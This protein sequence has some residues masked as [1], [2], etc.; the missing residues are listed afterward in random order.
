MSKIKNGGLHRYG[1]GPFEQ[2]QLGTAGVEGVNTYNNNTVGAHVYSHLLSLD[3]A[4][5]IC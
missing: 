1:A 4:V 3:L 5:L 2:H